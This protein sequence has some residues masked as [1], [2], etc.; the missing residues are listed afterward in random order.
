LL[1][2]G[3]EGALRL[4]GYG[5]P[6][7][8]FKHLT[9]AGQPRLVE[10]DKFGLR[11]FPPALVRFPAP[12]VMQA[13][14]PPGTLRLFIL[15]ESAALG[16]PRPQFG[17]GRYL[18]VLLRE[19]FPGQDFEVVNTAVTAI[20]SHVILPIARECAGHEGDLWI[21]YMGNNE[22][23]GPF[24]AATVFGRQAPPLA[25][26]R[27]TLA[28][29][30]ARLGQLLVALGRRLKKPATE[31]SWH[32]LEM[33]LE[34]K[35]PPADPRREVVYRSFARNLDDL[36][37]AGLRSGAKVLLSTVAVN[38]KDCPPF[39]TESAG[40]L[41]AADRAA[42]AKLCADA[43]A[44]ETRGNFAEAARACEQAARLC[45]R[46]AELQFR[47]ANCHLRLGQ[48]PAARR[49]YALAVDC[50]AL[51]CRADS[52]IN[53]L[54]AQARRRFAGPGFAF[55]DAAA[56]LAAASPAGIPGQESFYEHVHL[57]FDGN[58]RLARAWAHELEP[59]LP[60][61]TARRATGGWASQ[62]TCEGLL[63]LSDWNRLSVFEEMGGRLKQPPFS[64]QL[65]NARRLQALQTAVSDLQRRI[66]LA[67]PAQARQSYLEALKR[68]PEDHNLHENF[69]EFL[70]ATHDRPQATLERQKV[71]SLIPHCYFPH[72]SL[73]LL[74]K[75][76]GH[77]AEALDCLQKAAALNPRGGE[78]RLELGTVLARQNQWE[79]ALRQFDLARQF[80]PDNPRACLYS[81]EVLWKLDRPAESLERLRQALRLQPDY[82]EAHY[83]L[84]E[85]LALQ[86]QT[87]AA[88]DQFEQ[89]LR[90]NPAYLKAHL[91]LGVAFFKLGRAPEAARQFDEVLRLDPQNKQAAEF[92]QKA[93]AY[94]RGN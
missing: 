35:V 83:R 65:D 66:A 73:G 80:S 19:R 59:L 82:W 37:R 31:P 69:A 78:V 25:L 58:Y 22:M 67:S 24:G 72:Y 61:A 77:L 56:A 51:P 2:A 27:L 45:P 76:Q 18:E 7:S 79:A 54:I 92:R 12:V 5:F 8:F 70:E 3:L 49:A 30:R 9:I 57:N 44:A 53:G 64:G 40:D 93:T 88:A 13:R 34:N 86:G 47:L 43:L 52:R 62:E 14:K 23:V 28:I 84:G 81:G 89:V 71:C 75:E 36:V 50:D 90:L 87:A 17:A 48:A 91:N 60:P 32:G 6:T 10:N 1:L 26:V 20:N 41:P 74:L 39:A 42:Y 29:Q 16:E 21:I 38:L 15:G 11:F 33:F 46:S 63:G 4:G 94:P 55:C 68:A 85:E